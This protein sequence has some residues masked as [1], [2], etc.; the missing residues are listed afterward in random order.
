MP[1][2]LRLEPNSPV[3]RML[4]DVMFVV[5]ANHFET[6]C[7]W[8]EFKDRL[9]WRDDPQG[10]GV[11]LGQLDGRPVVVH[12]RCAYLNDQ[13]IL[14]TDITSEVADYQMLEDWLAEYC[15]PR[16]DNNLRRAHTNAGNFHLCLHAVEA[17][18]AAVKTAA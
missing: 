9:C 7:L 8:R 6:M 17:A 15:W 10:F 12:L 3:L 13:K 4:A 5:E 16:Y 11:T 1:A 14:F 18:T 2:F